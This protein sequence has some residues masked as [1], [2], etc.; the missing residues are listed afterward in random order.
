MIKALDFSALMNLEP[1]IE[2]KEVKTKVRG[3]AVGIVGDFRVTK[4]GMIYYSES[5]KAE[6][7][8]RVDDKGKDILKYLDII[9]GSQIKWTDGTNKP[10]IFVAI[11]PVATKLAAIQGTEKQVT[12]IDKYFKH[13]ANSCYACNWENNVYIDFTLLRDRST[14]IKILNIPRVDKNGNPSYTR[15]ENCT[16][17]PCIPSELVPVKIATPVVKQQELPFPENVEVNESIV[18]E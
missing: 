12:F 11:Q 3:L 14:N 2:E 15:R 9:D 4:S 10:F 5:F 13:M 1:V 6:L 17:I 16:W 7:K 8:E 18:I